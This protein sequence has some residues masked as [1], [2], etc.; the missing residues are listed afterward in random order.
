[1]RTAAAVVI[2]LTALLHAEADEVYPDVLWADLTGNGEEEQIR[3]VRYA[4]NQGD[5]MDAHYKLS[6]LSADG[7]SLWEDAEAEYSFYIGHS[8]VEDLQ[9]AADI[10]GDGAIEI[11]SPAAMSDVSPCLFR[12]FTWRGDRFTEI[13]GGYLF[14]DSSMP[15]RFLWTEDERSEESY[16]WVGRFLGVTE[17]GLLHVSVVGIDLDVM[18]FGEALL[19]PFPGGMDAV[20]WPVAPESWE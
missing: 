16:S 3:L 5:P 4:M 20:S 18:M 9:A 8:G 7:S 15:D 19:K 2:L 1:M 17:Q 11:I 12:V 6:V 10:N 13:E 14:G